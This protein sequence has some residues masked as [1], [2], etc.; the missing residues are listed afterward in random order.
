[1]VAVL[2]GRC[3]WKGSIKYEV[4]AERAH[5][6]K[7]TCAADLREFTISRLKYEVLSIILG[8]KEY[9]VVMRATLTGAL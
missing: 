8:H 5:L 2:W 6:R 3:G 7:F 4:V 9:I 1:M